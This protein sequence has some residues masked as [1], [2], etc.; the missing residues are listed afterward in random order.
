VSWQGGDRSKRDGMASGGIR[1]LIWW[2]GLMVVGGLGFG[3]LT[4]RRPFGE[5]ILVHPLVI[6]FFLVALGLIALRVLLAKPVPNV[7]S[8]RALL[9]G[10]L[11]GL[12]AFLS[13]NFLGVYVFAPL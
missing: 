2:Y 5:A 3:V 12:V 13:G 10:C 7:I 11:V 9:T 8:D 4:D 6:F 1:A